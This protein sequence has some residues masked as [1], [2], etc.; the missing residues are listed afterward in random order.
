[1]VTTK[2]DQKYTKPTVSALL[3]ATACEGVIGNWEPTGNE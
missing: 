2:K 1:M 3:P